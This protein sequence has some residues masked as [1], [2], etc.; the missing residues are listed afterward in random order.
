MRRRTGY[1]L[2]LSM[3]SLLVI[4]IVMLSST[5]AFASD[6]RGDMSYYIT[7]QTRW[8][9]VGGAALVGAALVD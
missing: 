5:G 4:G 1:V 7:L 2:I 9:V 8:L 3:V 6:S